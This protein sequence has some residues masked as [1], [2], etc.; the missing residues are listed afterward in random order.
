MKLNMRTVLI[1]FLAVLSTGAFAQAPVQTATVQKIGYVDMDSILEQLPAHKQVMSD[2]K[3]HGSQLEAQFKAKYNEYESKLKDYQAKAATM[4]DAV[5]KDKETELQQL[6]Q[7]IQKF[8]QDAQASVQKKEADLMNPIYRKI[9][10]A[11][12]EVAKENGYSLIVNAQV[13]QAD[14]LLYTDEKYDVSNLVLKKLGVSA[15][16]QIPKK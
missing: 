13:G 4:I 10:D 1:V 9:G 12:R 2:L 3:A 11:I 14:I 16:A 6:E 8:Q 7:N 5:R 15:T